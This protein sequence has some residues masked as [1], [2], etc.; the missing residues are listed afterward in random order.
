MQS[1]HR[2][3]HCRKLVCRGFEPVRVPTSQGRPG[4]GRRRNAFSRLHQQRRVKPAEL[5]RCVVKGL[6]PGKPVDLTH[7]NQTCG[8]GSGRWHRLG[9]VEQEVLR[10][11]INHAWLTA[12]QRRVLRNDARRRAL[13]VNIGRA[14]TVGDSLEK[15]R[16]D[17]PKH[18][19]FGL[20][21]G[22]RQTKAD[23]GHCPGS[24]CVTGTHDL[25]H[26]LVDPRAHARAIGQRRHRLRQR[27]VD[28]APLKG[29]KIGRMNPV[30]ADQLQ[31]IAVLGKQG[32][33][34]RI[35]PFE[36]A[37]EVFRQGKAGTLDLVGRVVTA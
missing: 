27:R 20:P 6:G 30:P 5:R 31:D 8:L 15:S 22:R 21:G 1:H 19:R 35:F 23:I 4:L 9:T 36:H 26:R 28:P 2:L 3:G 18:P 37:L 33:G 24:L 29:P 34:R 25:Q 16:A 14:Q 13:D 12:R 17:L 10:E 7:R 32:H 11:P